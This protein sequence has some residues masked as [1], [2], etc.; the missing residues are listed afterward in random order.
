MNRKRFLATTLLTLQNTVAGQTTNESAAIDI[1]EL[2][3]F[4]GSSQVRLETTLS[5]SNTSLRKGIEL[6]ARIDRWG[7]GAGA[8]LWEGSL[9]E[10]QEWSSTGQA[11]VVREITGLKPV[12][13]DLQS[14]NLYRLTVTLQREN[15]A[16]ASR[17]VRFGFRSFI[18][19]EG[20]FFLNGRR[21]FL[22]GN[23]INAPG[24]GIV[25]K[26]L[27]DRAFAEAYI[28]DMKHRNINLI[29]I[30]AESS[31]LWMDVCDEL[32]MLVFQGRYGAPFGASRDAAPADFNKSILQYKERDFKSYVRH[33][34]VVINILSNE[35]PARGPVGEAYAVFLDRA[36]KTLRS[37]DPNRLYIDNAGFGHGRSGDINDQHPYDG[38]YGGNFVSYYRY[39]TPSPKVQPITLSETVGAYTQA[40]G[41]FQI[42]GKQL[43]PALAWA[44]HSP[45]P[46]MDGFEYQTFLTAQIIESFRRMRPINPSLAGVMPFTYIFKHW[47]GVSHFEQMNPKPVADQMRISYQPILLSWELWTPQVYAGT[48]LHPIAHIVNDADDG[49]PMPGTILIIILTKVNDKTS[50]Y[51]RRVEVP[52]IPYYEV[53]SLPVE[54]PLP[55]TLPTG[56]YSLHGRLER[57]GKIVSVNRVSLFIAA[58]TERLLPASE[59]KPLLYDPMGKTGQALARIG[60]HPQSV[61]D[62]TLLPS[63]EDK[64]RSLI[65]GEGA[66][67]EA[68]AQQQ[69]ALHAFVV[70]G[71][72]VLLL[73]QE[74]KVMAKNAAVWLGVDAKFSDSSGMWINPERP[75]H[76]VFAGIPRERLRWWSDPG[77]WDQ[78]QPGVPKIAPVTSRFTLKK[79]EDLNRTAILADFGRGLATIALGEVFPE[80]GKGSVIVSCFDLISRI[81]HDPVADR[82]LRNLVAY[83]VASE[84]HH[85]AP[86]IDSPILWGD[87]RSERGIVGGP[88]YGLLLNVLSY[89]EKHPDTPG[90][91]DNISKPNGRRPFGPF[92]Y[93]GNCHIVE[94]DAK[95]PVGSGFFSARLPVGR[96]RLATTVRNEEKSAS[97]LTVAINGNSSEPFVVPAGKTVTVEVPLTN[98]SADTVSVNYTG[99]KSLILLRS[100][101]LP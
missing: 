75:D 11:T 27:T 79:R 5:V 30:G 99:T 63:L 18:T 85:S 39:R 22:R 94:G 45:T 50:L 95:S 24:R 69:A 31:D 68:E 33:P 67:T 48:T 38:W 15:K 77:G 35:M 32:G 53:K 9:G 36:Y 37:W 41:D 34:S 100:E 42:N 26:A 78:T 54:L 62:L 23:A 10:P 28:R 86:L 8:P 76:P 96:N 65:I 64:T 71:G 74:A 57:D 88:Q 90:L 43:A 49:S 101:F 70:R 55:D 56:N 2:L 6:R 61:V 98:T 80:A 59:S 58:V 82:L 12:L 4:A 52:P 83:N 14:P 89:E 87:Y 19:R 1:R 84:G 13:W 93:D 47:A 66:M 44:G 40:Q 7:K 16:V 91:L 21:L 92:S 51:E 17:S 20:Q 97:Q 46:Q 3:P 29:R 81:G 60:I 72:R 25:P 73:R